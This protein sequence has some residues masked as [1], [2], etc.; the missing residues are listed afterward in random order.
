VSDTEI[1]Q[2]KWHFIAFH[3]VTVCGHYSRPGQHNRRI[4]NAVK[5]V[6]EN[7][8]ANAKRNRQQQ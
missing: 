6:S 3:D 7:I 4:R 1:H 8:T 2:D 5:N